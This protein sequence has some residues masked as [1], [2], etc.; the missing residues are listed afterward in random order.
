MG[1][2]KIMLNTL[3]LTPN[4]LVNFFNKCLESALNIALMKINAKIVNQILVLN[5]SK[6]IIE[7]AARLGTG[8]VNVIESMACGYVKD[9]ASNRS[10]VI[11][12]TP[13]PKSAFLW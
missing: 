6:R 10:N 12:R 4:D 8:A 5:G 9:T 7:Y 13:I 3:Q 1:W 11:D 2:P